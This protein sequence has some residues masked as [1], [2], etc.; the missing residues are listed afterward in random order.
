MNVIFN[1]PE[2]VFGN[3][4][5]ITNCT[6]SDFALDQCPPNSQV[7]LITVYAN[8]SGDPN[9]LLGTAPLY[10]VSPQADQTALIEFNVP[11]LDIPI[12]IPVTVRTGTDY[13]LRFT[14]SDITQLTPLAE[15][16]PDHLGLPG[17]RTPQRRALPGGLPGQT[18]RLP[19]I[20]RHVAATRRRR[21][22]ASRTSR[23]P[24]TRPTAAARPWSPSSLV[25]TYQDPGNFSDAESTYPE[26]D[27]MRAGDVQA[28]S[29]GQSDDRRDRLGVGPRPRTSA[30]SSSRDS[31]PRPRRSSPPSSPCPQGLTINPDAADGQSACTDAQANFDSEGPA[32]CPDNSKIGTLSVGS[33]TL[34]GRLTGLA[35]LRRTEARQPVPA[36]HDLLRL[37]DAT[38]SWSG[39]SNRTPR[40]DRSPPTSKTCRRFRSKT[41]TSTSS[42]PIAA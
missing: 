18:G 1:A 5:A 17:E 25:E 6:P 35:L 41:S 12:S 11:T 30:P 27:R 36:L 13:G 22:R 21:N 32:N 28:A 29:P 19:G 34:D 4:N 16:Q 26:I 39:R 23:S 33:P 20:G 38:P 37:R 7:G 40:P 42:P 15:R 24:T 14:V 31:R 9:F 3:I 10:D 8:Y 2:G